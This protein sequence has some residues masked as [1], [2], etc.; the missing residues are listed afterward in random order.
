MSRSTGRPIG[1]GDGV[2]SGGVEGAGAG[3]SAAAGTSSLACDPPKFTQGRFG[4][5]R[6]QYFDVDGKDSGDGVEIHQGG[7]W[8]AVGRGNGAASCGYG[9][10]CVLPR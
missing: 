2:R 1:A 7:V 5:S 9:M 8:G 3:A 10:F 4:M 6:P